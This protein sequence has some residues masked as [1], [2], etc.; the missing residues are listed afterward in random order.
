METEEELSPLAHENFDLRCRIESLTTRINE[1]AGGAANV[2]LHD[3]LA[4]A[5]ALLASKEAELAEL[6]ELFCGIERE[7][8]E[9]RAERDAALSIAAQQ[10]KQQSSGKL[11]QPESLRTFASPQIADVIENFVKS[12]CDPATARGKARSY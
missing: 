1:L 2:S 8:A 4:G 5:R 3:E 7:T 12:H 6:N 10:A 11:P 9:V